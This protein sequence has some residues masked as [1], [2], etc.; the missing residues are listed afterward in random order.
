M[1]L[2]PNDWLAH[3]ELLPPRPQTFV[4]QKY[5]RLFAVDVQGRPNNDQYVFLAPNGL[6][7]IGLAPSHPLIAAHRRETGYKPL[8]LQYIPPQLDGLAAEEVV[9]AAPDEDAED[10]RA[11]GPGQQSGP[12]AGS[13]ATGPQGPGEEAEG[14]AEGE[15]GA[16]GEDAA[17][18]EAAAGA[19]A[20]GQPEAEATG[21]GTEAAA[22]E[23]G[24]SGQPAEA[25]AATSGAKNKPRAASQPSPEPFP[26]S[27]CAAVNLEAGAGRGR[28]KQS[29]KKRKASGPGGWGALQ[30]NTLLA[31]VERKGGDASSGFPV[32]AVAG[33]RLLELNE[34]LA[35]HPELLYDRP[36]REGF[37]AILFPT[38]D[39]ARQLRQTLLGE[40]AYLRLRGLCAEDLL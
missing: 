10:D 17:G 32:W 13:A 27:Q 37:V 18:D 15:A 12:A 25:G 19:G 33:G 34:R 6:A 9:A 20:E 22:A 31:R 30:G 4:E 14:G 24:R 1:A 36:C 2:A 11:Q 16:G 23:A 3:P 7:V 40:A 26:L 39:R 8:P 21:G 35:A 5:T 38:P 29:G 28:Q